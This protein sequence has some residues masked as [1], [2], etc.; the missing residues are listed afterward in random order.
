MQANATPQAAG[1]LARRLIE[2]IS[3]PF[4]I[5]GQ[6]IN[7]AS[8]S[9]SRSRRTTAIAADQLLKYADLALYRA[10]A[11]GRGTYRFFEPEMDAR[12]QARRALE[13]DLRHAL[14]DGE[15]DARTTSR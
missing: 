2:V 9:A 14:A 11:E 15:F 1:A 6:E 13:V 12:M 10:K 7:P 3:E 8:A 5:D 4:E